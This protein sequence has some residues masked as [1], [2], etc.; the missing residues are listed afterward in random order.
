MFFK[1]HK[2]STFALVWSKTCGL[3][4]LFQCGPFNSCTNFLDNF[5][6]KISLQVSA[7]LHRFRNIL[8]L[9]EDDKIAERKR[10]S[11][12]RSR[13]E[14]NKCLKEWFLISMLILPMLYSIY[15]SLHIKLLYQINVYRKTFWGNLLVK[16][17]DLCP[18]FKI[19][20]W[21]KA[22][23]SQKMSDVQPLFWLLLWYFLK[24]PETTNTISLK[25]SD[26]S[27]NNTSVIY[28]WFILSIPSH[29]PILNKDT[30]IISYHIS[31]LSWFCFSIWEKNN[32]S[33]Y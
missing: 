14:E 6:W 32:F 21:I 12:K 28:F 31:K 11:Q 27:L 33:R 22:F 25:F 8:Q 3:L 24:L 20:L 5:R 10:T 19:L 7:H 4:R 1:K 15:F 26:F 29:E 16:L 9:T 30:C 18:D 13:N 17:S 2:L 23:F